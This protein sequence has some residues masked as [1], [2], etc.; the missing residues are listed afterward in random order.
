MLKFVA[1]AYAGK[2]ILLGVSGGIA[3]VDTV[4]LARELRR[5]GAIVSVMMTHSAQK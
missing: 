4:R 1:I 3:A 2:K 5:H